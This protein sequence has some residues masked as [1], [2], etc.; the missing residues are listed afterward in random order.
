MEA[1]QHRSV[2]WSQFNKVIPLPFGPPTPKLFIPEALPGGPSQPLPRDQPLGFSQCPATFIRRLCLAQA[3]K[4][5]GS[6]GIPLSFCLG[7]LCL[8]FA[9]N[10]HDSPR[11]CVNTALIQNDFDPLGK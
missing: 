5:L 4:P 7:A 8:P 3:G 9:G 11:L 2:S 6:P 1:F 10:L